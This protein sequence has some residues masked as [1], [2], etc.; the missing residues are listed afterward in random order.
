MRRQ[1]QR[2]EKN[3][4]EAGFQKQH[5]PL[6]TEKN[7]THCEVGQ[8]ENP[9]KYQH[10]QRREPNQQ[11]YRQHNSNPRR[12][13]EKIIAGI[14]PEK[15]WVAMKTTHAEMFSLRDKFSR[16][17]D[18]AAANKPFNLNRQRQERAKVDETQEPEKRPD[19]KHVSA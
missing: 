11:K 14:D 10:G 17:Q 16:R 12:R 4:E 13:Y 9:K 19:R 3:C 5:V 15:C 1:F 2:R 6:I 8:I 7:P 18:S